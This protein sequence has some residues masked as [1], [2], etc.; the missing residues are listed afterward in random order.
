LISLYEIIR[1]VWT[2][3]ITK[4][5]HRVLDKAGVLHNGQIGYR[6]DQETMMSLLQV[7]NKIEGAYHYD[8]SKHITFWDIRRAFDY[9]PEKLQKLAW[10]QMGVSKGVA[11]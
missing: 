1:I 6:L 7:I 4:R 2:T 5:I 11:E 8:T 9:I 10:M 3:T